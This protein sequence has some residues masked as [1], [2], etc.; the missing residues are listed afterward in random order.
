MPIKSKWVQFKKELIEALAIREAGV[1]EVGRAR[2]NV[3]LYIGKSSK[4]IRSRLLDHKEKVAF[5]TCTHFRK[6]RTSTDAVA[7]AEARLLLDFK[8]KHGR[9]PLL[10]KI[11]P[12]EEDSFRKL[13]FFR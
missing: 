11:K 4:S 5:A 13:I 10:N 3:V 8:K 7:K 12:P 2:G 1:Y 6:R 9:Y